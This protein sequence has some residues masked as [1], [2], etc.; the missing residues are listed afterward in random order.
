VRTVEGRRIRQAFVAAPG[1]VL[2]SADYSQ[3]ELRVM[4]HLADDPGLQ[5]AF[6]LGRDIH[7]ETAARM[8]NL[9]PDLVDSSQ[10]AAAKTI[11]FGVLYGMGPQR[12]AREIGVSQKEAK[13]FIERYFERFPA[14][15]R[16][17]DALL[18]EARATSEVR[19][20]FGRRRAVPGIHSANPVDRSAA[21]R[22][23]VNTPVQGTA[24][25]LIKRAMLAVDRALAASGLAATVLLQVHDELLVECPQAEAEAV[26]ALLREAMAGAGLLPDGRPMK[27]PLQV[28]VRWARTWAE[29]H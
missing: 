3:I 23:A 4:A 19:T 24:A 14:V 29:A 16:W 2:V 12:L 20:L 22:I 6:R 17:M 7:R 11:N 8:F 25:D 15:H 1:C 21:E 5:E 10:R 13:A 26:A 9:L 27:V 28:D 18:A